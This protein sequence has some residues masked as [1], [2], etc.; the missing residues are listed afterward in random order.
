M[1]AITYPRYGQVMR[2]ENLAD[3]A[4]FVQV[5]ESAGLSAAARVLSIPPNTVSRTVTRLEEALGVR[6]MLRTTRA[7]HLT[8]EGRTFH[9]RAIELLEVA[10]RAEDALGGAS[11]EIAG[12]V[13]VAVRTTTVQ[14]SFVPDLLA[15][16]EQHPGLQVQLQVVDD[17]LDLVALGLDLAV[18]VGGQP[19][20]SLR[21]RSVGEV[22]FVLAATPAYLNRAARPETPEALAHHECIRQ[23]LGP[24]SAWNLRGPR[25]KQVSVLVGGRFGSADVRTQREAIYAGFGVGLRPIGEVARAET[26]GELERVLPRWSL[27]PLPVYVLQPPRRPSRQRARAIEL[28]IQLIE[29]AVQR[30]AFGPR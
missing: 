19:N 8:E 3:V 18:R 1:A 27:E 21:M 14:F 20:S 2:L 9:E 15:L 30:M 26:T 7:M 22:T 28:V 25:G 16:L 17:D 10:R 12:L 5:V 4:V 29:R 6:L 24:K 11:A 23:Q 13:R